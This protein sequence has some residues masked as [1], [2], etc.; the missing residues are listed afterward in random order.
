MAK[1]Q[2][3]ADESWTHSSPPLNRYHCFFG[4]IFGLEQ[5]IDRL[6]YELR[7]IAKKHCINTEIKWAK[8]SPTYLNCYKEL[9]DCLAKHILSGKIKYRQ[10]FKDR[11]YHFD[12]QQ[13]F[14]EL[15]MQFRLYYQ[16]LKNS[17]GFK[18]LPILKN[19]EKHHILLRLDG[20]SSQKHK[21][22]LAEFITKV[23]Q[24][25]QRT[26]IEIQVS[27][28][29]SSKFIRLQICDLLMGA[30]GYK[31]NKVFA[32]RQ[33][34][35]RGMTKKQK[36]KLELANYIYNVFKDINFRDRGAK[37]LSW[38]ESTGFNGSKENMYHHKFRVWK[39][40]PS[41][42]TKNK[43]WENDNLTKEGYLI[44]DIFESTVQQGL[45]ES[46]VPIN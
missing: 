19:N 28:I 15:D 27:Y 38:F 10:M 3:F 33:P 45:E 1:Y 6:D 24:Y 44:K 25:F 40:I 17:F 7:Q 39:F 4:G 13:G 5:D 2:V 21:E 34:K 42:Y 12:N 32:R 36:L 35:Q 14:S 11:S 30:A 20:H 23:P 41:V 9:V 37:A 31:G 29:D 18:Y 26:D 8:I 46:D 16:F 43:G 22:N